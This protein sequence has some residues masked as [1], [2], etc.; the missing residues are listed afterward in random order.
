MKRAIAAMADTLREIAGT[1][2]LWSTM[3]VAVLF[4]A[5]Y[6][7]APYRHQ[8]VT[9]LPVAV[10]DEEGSEATRRI[11]AR[12]D[13]TRELAVV[14]RVANEAEGL[15]LVRE[16]EVDG[17]LRLSSGLTD[18]IVTG[19]GQ[20][21]ISLQVNGAYLLRAQAV[22]GALEAVIRA[23]AREAAG[24]LGGDFDLEIAVRPLFNT[25]RGY[26]DYIFPAV[27]VVI[28]QQT[29]LF[30]AAMLAAR[31][32]AGGREDRDPAAFAGTLAALTLI[33]IVGA[34]FYFGPVFWLLDMP[35]GGNIPALLVAVPLF[36]LCVAALGLAI[37]G[38]LDE[39]DRAMELL[40]P[41]SLLVFFLS[42]AAW[43]VEM[44]PAWVR[45]VAFVSPASHGVPLFLGLNQMGASLVE[46]SR[47]LGALAL[48]AG[49][50]V[51]LAAPRR[52]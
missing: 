41:T 25:T 32:R 19:S 21:G 28:L 48:L 27:S 39:G 5:F 3:L 6:Y 42:G 18:R 12:L 45:A 10:V 49:G 36:S 2:A 50:A 35:R 30:G 20:G 7:P 40:V 1:R 24:R 52:S 14:A 47:P 15:R 11:V 31:R 26:A 33:G 29:L 23:E 51:L 8:A 17:V 22:A 38:W 16:R 44:M 9:D 34:L 43:P 4:Y 37:G 46:M 13:D